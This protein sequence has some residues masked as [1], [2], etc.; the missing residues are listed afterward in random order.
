MWLDDDIKKMQDN[1]TKQ[2]DVYANTLLS[3]CK[4]LTPVRS[5]KLRNG[6]S[7]KKS[8][9]GYLIENDVEYAKYVNFG[10]D[11]KGPVNM[12]AKALLSTKL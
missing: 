9:N 3:K 4:A 12:V 8:S 7:I 2:V 11:T 6:W 10:T 1:L 5:G